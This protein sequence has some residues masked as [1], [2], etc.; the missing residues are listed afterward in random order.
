MDELRKSSDESNSRKDGQSQIPECH[1]ASPVPSR[2]T[3]EIVFSTDTSDHVQGNRQDWNP[4]I[5]YHPITK[6]YRVIV[7]FKPKKAEILLLLDEP[8]MSNAIVFVLVER[9]QNR[10]FP[11][12]FRTSKKG[13]QRGNRQ[14]CALHKHRWLLKDTKSLSLSKPKTKTWFCD[15]RHWPHEKEE[16]KQAKR[17]K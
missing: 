4:W 10:F 8:I 6:F 14:C 16:K 13:F 9:T 2:A 5:R 17:K 1:G 15:D 11:A 7:V 3:R 12:Y